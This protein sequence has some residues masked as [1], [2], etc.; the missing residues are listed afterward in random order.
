[1]NIELI[2]AT[3][4]YREQL[5]EMLT[6]WKNDIIVNHT[7][8]SPW[9]IWE[10]DF[11][12]FDHY[13]KNLDTKEETKDGWVPDTTLFCYDTDRNIFVGAVNIRHY[14]NDKL[15]KTGGHI[16]GGVRPGERKK[17]YAT[18]MIGL[19]LDECKRL[20]INKVLICCDKDNIGS[21]KSIINNGGI[22]EN[23]VEE[24]GHI[25]QRY[26]IQL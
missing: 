13:L 15:L 19:A 1:M 10:N 25:E 7:D 6:E 23:E 5:F 4:E 16:G 20:G 2:R 12:D 17:G 22:L 3:D 8:M 21:A 11:H 18:A 24:N 14:L 26:W 9:K